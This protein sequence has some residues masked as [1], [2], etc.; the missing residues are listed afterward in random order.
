MPKPHALCGFG[1]IRGKTRNCVLI[2]ETRNMERS[3]KNEGRQPQMSRRAFALGTGSVAALFALGAAGPAIAGTKGVLRPPGGQDEKAFIA[4]CLMCDKCRS[5]CPEN[6]LTTCV[7]EDGIA[8]FRT[9]RIDFRKGYCTFCD[10]C[11]EVCPTRALLPFDEGKDSIGIA[12]V[13]EDEYIAFLGSGCHVCVDACRYGAISL[14]ATDK[15]V[16]DAALCNGCGQC[17]FE[18]PSAKYRVW[19]GSDKR[20]INVEAGERR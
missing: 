5:I 4:S 16:V 12:V 18:C 7:L 20:G 14:S 11:I 15:P 1:R 2:D 19:T 9:P 17:E 3:S 6:C 13:N 10:E 8:N